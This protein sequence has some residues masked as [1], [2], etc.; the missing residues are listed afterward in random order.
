MCLLLSATLFHRLISS[1]PLGAILFAAR[2]PFA[3]A[4]GGLDLVKP[5]F[6]AKAFQGPWDEEPVWKVYKVRCLEGTTLLAS[7][8][9]P[10]DLRPVSP[11]VYLT[12][13]VAGPK[14]SSVFRKTKL[15]YGKNEP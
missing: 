8:F 13:L 12:L 2:T 14:N 7:L 3:C 15:Y 5:Q 10:K 4:D 11:S 1:Y 6:E 9:L